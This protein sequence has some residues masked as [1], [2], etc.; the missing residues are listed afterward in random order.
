M[1]EILAKWEPLWL[2][3]VLVIGLIF[4][5]YTAY[6]VKKEYDYDE[7]KDIEKKQKRTKTT[8]KT[9]TQPGGASIVEEATEV[10]EPV[11]EELK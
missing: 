7:Q 11:K 2:L 4:E 10:T 6:V 9:T 5:G 3:V 8:K 1:L